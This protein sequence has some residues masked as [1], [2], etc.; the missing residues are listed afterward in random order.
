MKTVKVAAILLVA[1]LL[2]VIIN[3]T[4]LKIIID[5]I[6]DEVIAAEEEDADAAYGE[7]S[8]IFEKYKKKASYISLTVNH[9]DLTDIENS[10]AEII[11]AAKSGDIDGVITIKSRLI[12][13]LTHLGRL[14]GINLDSIF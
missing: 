10:F 14:T 11:G 9:E 5:E 8:E 12:S 6:T 2:T 13:A 7:Y 3:S 4:V 1:T